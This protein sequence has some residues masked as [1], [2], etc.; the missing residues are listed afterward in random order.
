MRV[1]RKRIVYVLSSGAR[2]FAQLPE[3][4]PPRSSLPERDEVQGLVA[5]GHGAS[6]AVQQS[7]TDSVLTAANT[8]AFAN[9]ACML[10]HLV[11]CS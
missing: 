3:L 5:L 1:H 6:S 9:E 10:H 2:L 4:Q 11:L 7:W 8:K